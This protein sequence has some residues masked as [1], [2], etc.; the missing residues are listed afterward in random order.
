MDH[1]S[2]GLK[3]KDFSKHLDCTFQTNLTEGYFSDVTLVCDDQTKIP[4][5]KMILS[6]CSPVL[7]TLLRTS[8][9]SHTSIHL[10]G[11]NQQELLTVLTFMY[12]GEVNIDQMYIEK[13]MELARVFEMKELI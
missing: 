9:D 13:C 5:H 1:V 6:A 12:Y 10:C 4:A 8:P 11:V 3:W 2:F 7:K